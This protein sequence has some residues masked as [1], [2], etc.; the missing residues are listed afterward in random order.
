MSR[1]N[2]LENMTNAQFASSETTH[3]HCYSLRYTFLNVVVYYKQVKQSLL[4]AYNES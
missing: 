1:E 2:V 4:I 3:L